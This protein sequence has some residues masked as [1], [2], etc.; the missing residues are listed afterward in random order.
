MA[1]RQILLKNSNSFWSKN[2][3]FL[4]RG[5]EALIIDNSASPSSPLDFLQYSRI[6]AE[7][8]YYFHFLFLQYCKKYREDEGKALSSLISA[9]SPL[10]KNLVYLIH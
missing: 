6:K 10:S 5:D 3:K 1:L 8:Q 9:S 4:E 7:F 2:T